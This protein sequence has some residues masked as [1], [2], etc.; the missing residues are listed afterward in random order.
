MNERIE[1]KFQLLDE[2]RL[3]PILL[4]AW[5]GEYEDAREILQDVRLYLQKMKVRMEGE[6]EVLPDQGSWRDIFTVAETENAR[7]TREI[8]YI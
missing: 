6:D 4:K 3:G 8:R 5:K 1:G 7:W 2:R